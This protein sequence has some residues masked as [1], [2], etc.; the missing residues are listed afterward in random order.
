MEQLFLIN[1]NDKRTLN[2]LAEE[3]GEDFTNL[4]KTDRIRLYGADENILELFRKNLL[5]YFREKSRDVK[6]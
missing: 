4:A 6:I 2:R 3:F 1:E 5:S